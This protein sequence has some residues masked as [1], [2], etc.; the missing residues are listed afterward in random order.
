MENKPHIWTFTS[1]GGTVRVKINSGAD[2]ANLGQLDRKLWSV[3]SCPAKSLEFDQKTLELIDADHDGNIR[4]DEVVATAEWLTGV[5]KNPDL[6]LTRGTEIPFDAFNT[7]NPEGAKL[8]ASAKQILTNLKLEKDSIA[9]EDTA[10][11]TKV[12]AD[13]KFNGDGVITPASPDDEAL[14]ALVTTITEIIGKAPTAAVST[15]SMPTI[16]K[17]STPPSRTMPPGRTPESVKSSLTATRPPTPSPPS[18][19]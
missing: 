16:S 6:L 3:L 13:S 10:D 5:L 9:L 11:L 1:V 4:V 15:V 7:E 19:R 18:M 14:A 2:I 17:L 8:L 12:F